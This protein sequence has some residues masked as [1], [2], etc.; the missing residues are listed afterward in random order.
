M[1]CA[2]CHLDRGDTH[3]VISFDDLFQK[4]AN[5]VESIIGEFGETLDRLNGIET[6]SEDM[7]VSV[8]RRVDLEINC[9]EETATIAVNRAERIVE[10]LTKEVDDTTKEI[11]RQTKLLE[12]L[13]RRRDD[14]HCMVAEANVTLESIKTKRKQYCRHLEDDRTRCRDQISETVRRAVDKQKEIRKGMELVT[15]VL[16]PRLKDSMSLSALNSCKRDVQNIATSIEELLAPLPLIEKT[17]GEFIP[18]TNTDTDIGFLRRRIFSSLEKVD[19]LS[20][21]VDRPC[22]MVYATRYLPDGDVVALGPSGNGWADAI[23]TWDPKHPTL[24]SIVSEGVHPARD[25]AVSSIGEVMVLR[26]AEPLI[27]VFNLRT[28]VTKDITASL[29]VGIMNEVRYLATD[30]KSALFIGYGNPDRKLFALDIHGRKL[31]RA[32][33]GMAREMSYDASIGVLYVAAGRTI[34]RFHWN[35]NTIKELPTHLDGVG[36]FYAWD[37]CTSNTGEVFVAGWMED[38]NNEIRIYQLAEEGPGIF[39]LNRIVFNDEIARTNIPHICVQDKHLI[40]GYD[41]TMQLYQLLT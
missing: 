4:T 38:T 20:M 29:G 11:D 3:D 14:T 5:D 6:Q 32:E 15:A 40:L 35:G 27:R 16:T 1:I 19:D 10:T 26:M 9:V 8:D 24:C 25:I 18:A 33:I 21:P 41:D 22:R 23:Y 30:L 36:G 31:G 34:A 13:V 28:G 37:I 17:I 7:S 2:A 12:E 39:K